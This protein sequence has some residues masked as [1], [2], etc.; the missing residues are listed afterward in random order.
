[1]SAQIHAGSA[2][3]QR[4]DGS[5][6]ALLEFEA[7]SKHFSKRLDVIE[8]FARRLGASVSEHTVHA[9]DKVTFAVDEREVVGLVGES[10]CGKSTLGRIACGLYEP[11]EGAV[12]YRG[13]PISHINGAQRPVQMIFQDPFASLNPRMRVADIVGEAPRVHGLVDAK[14]VEDYVAQLLSRVGLDADTCAA[15]RT[16][17]PAG[18]V[19]GSASPAPWR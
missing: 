12:R 1:M 14:Q 10:G 4:D 3:S 2:V 16:S 15:T 18:S 6:R 9:V 11:T 7:V 17:S 8:R 5:R 13:Q 19:P